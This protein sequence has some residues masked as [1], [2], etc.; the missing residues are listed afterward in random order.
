MIGY[1]KLV[2]VYMFGQWYLEE[3]GK[4]KECTYQKAKE[5]LEKYNTKGI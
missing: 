3:N 1:E 4:W 2:V 5:R